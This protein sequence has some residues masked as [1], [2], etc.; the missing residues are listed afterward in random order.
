MINLF[1]HMI[2]TSYIFHVILHD[3]FIFIHLQ[4][5]RDSFIFIHLSFLHN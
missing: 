5:L 1:L 4:F 3:S 2:D